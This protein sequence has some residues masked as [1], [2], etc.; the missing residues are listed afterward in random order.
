MKFPQLRERTDKQI[1]VVV[2]LLLDLVV[3]L[4]VG[5][6]VLSTLSST[7]SSMEDIEPVMFRLRTSSNVGSS[8]CRSPALGDASFSHSGGVISWELFELSSSSS[9]ISSHYAMLPPKWK[10]HCCD[11]NKRKPN[12]VHVL[13]PTFPTPV[14]PINNHPIPS[15]RCP[16]PPPISNM[17]RAVLV[18]GIYLSGGR[19][20]DIPIILCCCGDRDGMMAL[21]WMDDAYLA[22][23]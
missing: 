16:P 17:M 15:S 20:D 18:S 19:I 5:C 11:I 4:G 23:Q 12:V 22:V 2:S 3:E 21:L 9:W 6:F 8:S 13:D 1:F 10:Y 7:I 14:I